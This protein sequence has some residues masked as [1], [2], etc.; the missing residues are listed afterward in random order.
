VQA[1]EHLNYT[2]CHF[3]TTIIFDRS[4]SY[5]MASGLNPSQQKA[6]NTLSG[7]LL[8][9]AGAGSGKTRVVTYRIAKLINSGIRPGRILA[10]T[11]TNKAAKEMQQRTRELLGGK[12]REKPE[13]STFHSL[14]VRVL[15]R[16][17]HNLGY[18]KQFA[19]YDRGDQESVARAALREVKIANESLRPG[20]LLS[21]ISGWKCGS[22]R[23]AQAASMARTDKEHLGAVA[24]RR[25]QSRLQT[26]GALDFDD[27]L[28][29]TEDL[30]SQFAEVRSE[31]A[32]I[33]DHL[34]I[35]E[36]QDTNASQYR[37][38]KALAAGHR[39][40]CVVG[41][42]DQSIYGWRGAEVTHIL[43]FHHDWSGATV[44]RL[45]ENY[46]CTGEIL[47][48]ANRL[49]SFNKLRHDK[50]LRPARGP[51]G[52]P[53]ILQFPDE[54]AEAKEIVEEIARSLRVDKK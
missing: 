15:R 28:L 6:V 25:Y 11:F 23:P 48:I 46:R 37:I 27:L 18:P 29:C 41:D 38:I 45:E 47:K 49:I 52:K 24:Y 19:I 54:S 40:L 14:C 1:I 50:V 20:D 34:L 4:I 21:L 26:S 7:P 9:L 5:F 43:R 17:I 42:D 35:D 2:G 44:V 39:N 33:F 8:V 22:I 32:S 31:E 13:I 36:Y 30:F 10:V 53:R 51:G 3:A 12:L 16:N